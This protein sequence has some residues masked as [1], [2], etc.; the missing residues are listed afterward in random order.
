MDA[1]D[2]RSRGTM[3][4]PEDTAWLVAMEGWGM[5]WP[6]TM[7]GR[8][9]ELSLAALKGRRA[10]HPAA[11]SVRSAMQGGLMGPDWVTVA[12]MRCHTPID[13]CRLAP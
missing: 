8:W 1:A 12:L 7:A 6:K 13:A 5:V 4:W 9:F 10:D 3:C 11:G 2:Q